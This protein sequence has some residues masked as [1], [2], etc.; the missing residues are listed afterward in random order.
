MRSSLRI[1]VIFAAIFAALLLLHLPL[2]RL[3]YFWD[4]AGYY[5]PAAL[6]FFQG[7]S[8]LPHTTLP[9]GHTPLVIVY[10]GL[11]WKI[12]GYSP[13]VARGAMTLIAAATVTTIYSSARRIANAEIAFWTALLLALSPMFFAQTTLVHLD[14]GAALFTTLAVL[15]FL[16]GRPWLFALAASLAV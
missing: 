5:I 15:F 3:P 2:L 7:W 14:L 13:L 9:E 1:L 12:F 10:I 4:E 16:D 8:L 11:A 6:D